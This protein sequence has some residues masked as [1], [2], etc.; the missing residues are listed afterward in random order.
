MRHLALSPFTPRSIGNKLI[1]LRT[2]ES[3]HK[4]PQQ[5]S[6]G[7]FLHYIS[8]PSYGPEN[9]CSQPHILRPRIILKSSPRPHCGKSFTRSLDLDI[10][11]DGGV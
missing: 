5:G 4:T 9:L 8:K 10:G 2:P 6:L 7:E 1:S 3:R 11:Q